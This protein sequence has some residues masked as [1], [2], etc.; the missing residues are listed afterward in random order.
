M[1]GG[2]TLRDKTNSEDVNRIRRNS[3]TF[4]KCCCNNK[5]SNDV[6]VMKVLGRLPFFP[7]PLKM[8]VLH[9]Y[10]VFMKVRKSIFRCG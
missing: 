5:V 7:K 6:D 4:L 10:Y 2:T 1:N 9:I 8:N 3:R